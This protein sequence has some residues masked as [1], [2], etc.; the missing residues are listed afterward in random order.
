MLARSQALAVG[1]E[2]VGERPP[3]RLL[4]ASPARPALIWRA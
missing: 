2:L 3:G 4:G 1:E